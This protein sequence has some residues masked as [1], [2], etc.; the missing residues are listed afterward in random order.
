MPITSPVGFAD[1]VVNSLKAVPLARIVLPFGKAE[2]SAL[3]ELTHAATACGY[4]NAHVSLYNLNTLDDFYRELSRAIGFE[5]TCT[6]IDDFIT[7]ALNIFQQRFVILS[8]AADED[9]LPSIIDAARV[10]TS[11][12][13]DLSAPIRMVWVHGAS[14]ITTVSTLSFDVW[15]PEWRDI[16]QL[17]F[18]EGLDTALNR[19]LAHY[20]DRRVYW[21][22]TGQ[23]DRIDQLNELVSNHTNIS[24][25][26]RQIDEALDQVFDSIPITPR[27]RRVCVERLADPI[28]REFWVEAFAK[29]RGSLPMAEP[30]AIRHWYAAGLIWRPPGMYRWRLS[31]TC[32][33]VVLEGAN[34]HGSVPIGSLEAKVGMANAR[35]NPQLSQMVLV[36]TTQIEAELLEA[37]RHTTNWRKL[38]SDSSLI[39]ELEKQQQRSKSIQNHFVDVDRSSIDYATFGQLVRMA[40]CAG[41][42]FKFPLSRETL[43][44]I[45]NIRNWTAHGQSVR[46]EGLRRSVEAVFALQT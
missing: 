42:A 10:I 39:D 24:P 31:S 27:D 33:R 4:A 6:N 16:P 13:R 30:Q 45:A 22:A 17:S 19:A 46:W 37:L 3:S 36:L 2:N 8:D 7:E 34:L 32:V 21:E 40:Q 1:S 28:H 26:S 43:W 23:G 9:A 15:P 41:S 44:D 14:Q 11:A 5:R 38:A 20:V 29:G 35:A 18:A 25:M 12:S